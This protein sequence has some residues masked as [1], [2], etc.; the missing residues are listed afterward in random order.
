MTESRAEALAMVA[1]C[2]R[3]QNPLLVAPEGI[4]NTQEAVPSS[5]ALPQTETGA[6]EGY[7]PIGAGAAEVTVEGP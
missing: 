3:H 1:R 2:F 6:V 5:G 7:V 4:P